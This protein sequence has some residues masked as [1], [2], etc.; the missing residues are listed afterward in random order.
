MS[1]EWK[2]GQTF[3][4]RVDRWDGAQEWPDDTSMVRLVALS[5]G[6][7]EAVEGDPAE[8]FIIPPGCWGY[9]HPLL[10]IDPEDREQ[11][12][13]LLS[14]YH[15]WKW[16]LDIA[17]ASTDDMQAALRSLL[18]PPKPDEPM[19]LGAVV[20]D[21]EGVRWLRTNPSGSH[22]WTRKD[23]GAKGLFDHRPYDRLDVIRVLH[24]GWSE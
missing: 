21:R 9:V 24:E 4:A 19:G 12:A 11:V 15:K 22:Q 20:E 10:V 6:Y 17:E 18:E 14:R 8:P 16:S 1:R 7:L 3:L 2:P 5:D 13:A 23:A